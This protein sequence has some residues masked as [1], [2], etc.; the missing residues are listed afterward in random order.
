MNEMYDFIIIG[1]VDSIMFFHSVELFSDLMKLIDKTV[2]T[3]RSK[4]IKKEQIPLLEQAKCIILYRPLEICPVIREVCDKFEIP[5]GYLIDDNL[6]YGVNDSVFP[7]NKQLSYKENIKHVDFCCAHS[8]ILAKALQ[9]INPNSF[10]LGP[11]P[12]WKERFTNRNIPLPLPVNLKRIR[13]GLIAGPSHQH[14]LRS[15]VRF[16]AQIDGIDVVYFG[17]KVTNIKT[18]SV[19]EH[20]NYKCGPIKWYSILHR[21]RLNIIYAEL[22]DHVLYESKGNLKFRESAF[23]K[24]PLVVVDP[25]QKVYTCIENG[26]NGYSVRTRKEALM[27]L[28]DLVSHPNKI[29][30]LGESAYNTLISI[31]PKVNAQQIY[32]IL[33]KRK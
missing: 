19:V 30:R 16:I 28:K 13:I 1:F 8:K 29:I 20:Y 26:I 15:Q 18:K 14:P 33:P 7:F 5:L 2:Y 4:T 3:I 32:D 6:F 27:I 10:C 11:I 22:E 9:E 12:I 21:L 24:V 31:N 25:T 17:P 23:M